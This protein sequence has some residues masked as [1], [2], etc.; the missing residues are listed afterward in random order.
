MVIN[1]SVFMKI[2]LQ[3]IIDLLKLGETTIKYLESV[4]CT[5]YCQISG[6]SAHSKISE[7]IP[8]WRGNVLI[9][10]RPQESFCF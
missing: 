9:I 6:I 7:V 1:R 8:S 5:S 10:Y 2:W 3:W 4:I